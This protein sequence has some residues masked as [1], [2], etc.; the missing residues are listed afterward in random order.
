[1]ALIWR[2]WTATLAKKTNSSANLAIQSSIDHQWWHWSSMGGHTPIKDRSLMGVKPPNTPMDDQFWPVTD[3]I[4]HPQQ[5]PVIN[6]SK[7]PQQWPVINGSQLPQ[8]PPSMGVNTPIH[9]RFWPV[10]CWE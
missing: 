9:D 5:W 3:G 10:N 2:Y 8:T 7:H 6:G 1:M 4:K